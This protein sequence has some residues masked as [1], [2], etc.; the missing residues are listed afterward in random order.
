MIDW[1]IMDMDKK[2]VVPQNLLKDNSIAVLTK[3]VD[4]T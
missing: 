2:L 3:L 4:A 1:Y